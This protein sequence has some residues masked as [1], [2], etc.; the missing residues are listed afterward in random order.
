[1]VLANEHN[2]KHALFRSK[3]FLIEVHVDLIQNTLHDYSHIILKRDFAEQFDSK[4]V[5]SF[6]IQFSFRKFAMSFL[7]F[8]FRGFETS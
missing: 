3:F 6:P 8:L 1:M 5:I 2:P 4:H 7:T